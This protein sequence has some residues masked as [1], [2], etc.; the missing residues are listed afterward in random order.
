MK[1]ARMQGRQQGGTLSNWHYGAT[2]Y[3]FIYIMRGAV[4]CDVYALQIEEVWGRSCT[5]CPNVAM[6]CRGEHLHLQ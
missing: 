3:N 2:S 1:I 4:M 6:V 5:Y